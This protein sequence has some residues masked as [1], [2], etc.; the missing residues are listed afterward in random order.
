ME[1]LGIDI[2]TTLTTSA[3]KWLQGLGALAVAKGITGI[4]RMQYQ[5]IKDLQKENA[6]LKRKLVEN[7]IS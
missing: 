5:K 7:G 3:P 2:L 1:S 4:Y 6:E